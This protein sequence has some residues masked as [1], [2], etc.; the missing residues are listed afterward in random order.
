MGVAEAADYL[1]ISRQALLHR[2]KLGR[3][4]EPLAKLSMG[5]LWLAEDVRRWA[6]ERAKGG[7]GHSR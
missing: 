6:R 4:P 1:G 2:N 3:F 7:G 5:Y